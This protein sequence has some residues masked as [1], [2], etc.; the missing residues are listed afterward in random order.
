[1]PLNLTPDDVRFLIS[2]LKGEA[3]AHAARFNTTDQVKA[4]ILI[5][6][7]EGRYK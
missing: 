7:L 6:K 4:E 5:G 2:L 1:M 3:A